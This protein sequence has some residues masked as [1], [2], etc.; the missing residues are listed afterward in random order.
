VLNLATTSSHHVD[1]LDR[2]EPVGTH[3]VDN[4]IGKED[5]KLITQLSIMNF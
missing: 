1:S 5:Y 2:F 3:S 4:H